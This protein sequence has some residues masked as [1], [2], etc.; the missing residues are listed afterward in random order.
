[1]TDQPN[2]VPD[3]AEPAPLPEPEVAADEAVAAQE[4]EFVAEDA[5]AEAAGDAA[6]A[7]AAYDAADQVDA[8]VA[9]TEVVSTPA[10]DSPLPPMDE[11]T[12]SQVNPP[13]DAPAPGYQPPPDPGYAAPP[14]P[15][16]EGYQPPPAG[17]Y[18]P[19]GYEPPPAGGYAPP[20]TGGYAPP[21][22]PG[23]YPPAAYPQ[24][25]YPPAGYPAPYDPQAK[26][27]LVAGLLGILV[28]GFG[29]HRFYLGYTSIGIIQIVVT[30]L[31]C[32]VGALW[33]L[34]EGIM[35]LVGSPSFQT[36]ASGRPLRD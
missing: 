15:Q 12:L 3:P 23:G 5:A 13:P 7:G 19:P 11:P 29:V 14:P 20:P 8:A 18:P 25:G 28:G 34:V 26:S 36:D 9:E 30:I 4:S 1:M 17:A 24:G 2:A 27:K 22:A 10:G 16:P 21:P 33:G 6:P 35:I 31:T 32:G